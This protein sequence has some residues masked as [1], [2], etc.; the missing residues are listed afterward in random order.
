M[1]TQQM[2]LLGFQFVIS[3]VTFLS[4][5]ANAIIY[6]IRFS[7]KYDRLKKASLILIQKIEMITAFVF[8]ASVCMSV[9]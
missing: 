9:I 4:F 3:Y 2:P 1:K 8:Q 6:H 7:V 5:L